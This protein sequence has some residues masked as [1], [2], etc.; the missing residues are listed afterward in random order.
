MVQDLNGGLNQAIKN[1]GLLSSKAQII[2]RATEPYQIDK[3]DL[4][5]IE[6]NEVDSVSKDPN[7]LVVDVRDKER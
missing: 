2:E 6:I 3:W 5:T 1:H 4:P 7:Y